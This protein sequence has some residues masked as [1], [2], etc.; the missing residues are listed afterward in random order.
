MD[1]QND[2]IFTGLMLSDMHIR[3]IRNYTGKS[4][5]TIKQTK[6]R[7]EFLEFIQH[8]YEQ[9]GFFTKIYDYPEPRKYPTSEL[10]SRSSYEIG[11]QRD[12]WYPNGIKIIPK[13]LK[14]NPVV[15][16]FWI[17]G[18]GGVERCGKNNNSVKISLYTN[19]F[20]FEEIDFLRASIKELGIESTTHEKIK[21]QPIIL[22]SKASSVTKLMDM[23]RPFML[24]CFQY[25]VQDPHLVNLG[26]APSRTP[27]ASKEYYHSLS[28]E[29]RHERGVIAWDKRKDIANPERNQRYKD[30]AEFREH[31]KER[32]SKNYTPHP[33]IKEN[34]ESCH[35]CKSENVRKSGKI[36]NKSGAYQRFRCNN[37]QKLYHS[38][39]KIQTE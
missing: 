10:S 32:S 21:N 26:N 38:E 3:K 29:V 2:N 12:R 39:D 23:I 1:F 35:Y 7:R 15:M 36:L 13:D 22:I 11:E 9:D 16:A 27:E 8:Y 4:Y 30:D 5:F 14:L 20:T 24:D 34:M 28:P 37:C 33:R 25:K 17:M 31:C 19:C 18:D 6:R